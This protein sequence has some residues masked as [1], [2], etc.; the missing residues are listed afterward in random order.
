MHCLYLGPRFTIMY[1]NRGF[2]WFPLF[3]LCGYVRAQ[4]TRSVPAIQP[5]NL[6]VSAKFLEL[7]EY[8]DDATK[9]NEILFGAI[10]ANREDLELKLSNPQSNKAKSV[11]VITA[12]NDNIDQN[13][14]PLF[15]LAL[16]EAYAEI[17][18]YSL[19]LFKPPHYFSD[20]WDLIDY[21]RSS[22]HPVQGWARQFDYVIW[23]D[24]N[25]VILDM[26]MRMEKL[27]GKKSVHFVAS[28][29]FHDQKLSKNFFA[30]RNSLW[31]QE[32]LDDW[33]R[34]GRDFENE[35]DSAK[36]YLKLLEG[37][38]EDYEGYIKFYA[39]DALSTIQPVA[40]NFKPFNQ[41]LNIHD[42]LPIFKRRAFSEGFH[43][44]CR[45]LGD[46]S[47]ILPVQ[48]SLSPRSLLSMTLQVYNE[49]FDTKYREYSSRAAAGE[50][51]GTETGNL[52]FI[53]RRL[54]AVMEADGA[55]ENAQKLRSEAFRA[56]FLNFKK[57]RPSNQENKKRTGNPLPDWMDFLD[58]LT[59]IGTEY[60]TKLSEE[61]DRKVASKIM[62]ELSN[63]LS[64]YD[65][66]RYVVQERLMT[67]H[68]DMG[69]IEVHGGSQEGG[70]KHFIEAIRIG[71]VLLSNKYITESEMILPFNFAADCYF[72]LKRWKEAIVMYSYAL[73]IGQ[74]RLQGQ[75]DD[76]MPIIKAHYGIACFYDQRYRTAKTYIEQA[77]N[78]FA[79][80]ETIS[81]EI[82][83]FL[84]FAGNIYQ[85]ASKAKYDTK[86]IN[87]F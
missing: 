11:V 58:H 23:I 5:S 2:V 41:I 15:A 13:V 19:H 12:V 82:E 68:I 77:L 30:F 64:Q 26:G 37:N 54:A 78:F 7:C 86:I 4:I 46:K 35:F 81:E 52:A 61:D 47:T 70:L 65:S 24:T 62:L 49:L 8:T 75:G 10:E 50:N 53:I 48:L 29:G 16:K 14:D 38:E 80:K 18:D 9:Y 36:Y 79:E 56:M 51:N 6:K 27:F 76:L 84:E 87:E 66:K 21:L 17:N 25:S 71:R 39:V 45:A 20:D 1:Y 43:E 59:L 44:F 22:I 28:E 57:R 74:K 73:D 33:L 40:L 31:T 34:M 32:F 69:M 55:A 3:C 67:I 83:A 60:A 42:E 85:Q 63:E 72:H